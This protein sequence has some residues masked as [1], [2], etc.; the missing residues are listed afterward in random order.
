MSSEQEAQKLIEELQNRSGFSIDES[1]FNSTSK[2]KLILVAVGTALILAA[3]IYFIFKSGNKIDTQKNYR[4]AF[5]V[6]N[7]FLA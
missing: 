5:I 4:P 3:S 7:I 1:K 2:V 6:T